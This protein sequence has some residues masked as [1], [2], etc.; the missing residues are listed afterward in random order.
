MALEG[1][2]SRYRQCFDLRGTKRLQGILASESGNGNGCKVNSGF[3]VVNE[4]VV[5]CS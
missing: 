1:A 2:R 3:P 4:I 5:K